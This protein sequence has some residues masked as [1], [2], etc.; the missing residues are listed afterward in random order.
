MSVLELYTPVGK[1][2]STLH[3][4]LDCYNAAIL[5]LIVYFT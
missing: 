1:V 5:R 2:V 3:S 4:T